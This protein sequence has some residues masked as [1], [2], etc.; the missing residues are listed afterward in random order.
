[1]VSREAGGRTMD[2]AGAGK[3]KKKKKMDLKRERMMDG[4]T[5]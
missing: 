2:E 1:M 5:Y 3:K 4:E